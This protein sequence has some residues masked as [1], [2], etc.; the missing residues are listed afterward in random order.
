MKRCIACGAFVEDDKDVCPVCKANDFKEVNFTLN[1]KITID[2]QKDWRAVIRVLDDTITLGFETKP[3]E[4]PIQGEVDD[5]LDGVYDYE[6]KI[7]IYDL[8]MTLDDGFCIVYYGDCPQ[9]KHAEVR[10]K[11]IEYLTNIYNEN[12]KRFVK[13]IKA[14]LKEYDE[15]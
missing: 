1:E 4:I 14:D 7:G 10:P 11:I 13:C 8:E 12:K 15:L 2:E 3:S 5:A 6:T 9:E